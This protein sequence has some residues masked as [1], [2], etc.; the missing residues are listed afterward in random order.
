MIDDDDVPEQFSRSQDYG[1]SSVWDAPQD[2]ALTDLWSTGFPQLDRYWQLYPGQF[3][4]VTGKAG[5]GKSTFLFNV[6]M[7]MAV[8]DGHCAAI[9]VPEN[10]GH[11]RE[12]FTDLW[13]L[14]KPG[15]QYFLQNQLWLQSSRSRFFADEPMDIVT[16][17]QRIGDNVKRRNIDVVLLDPFNEMESC[18]PREQLEAEYIGDL[19]RLVKNFA[20]TF[21]VAI[22][23]VAHPTKLPADENRMPT[24]YDISGSA[25]WANKADHLLVLGRHPDRPVAKVIVRKVRE[26]KAGRLGTVEFTVDETTGL[27]T[28]IC[29]GVDYVD[30]GA[31]KGTHRGH[32]E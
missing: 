15:L 1:F 12:A 6:L 5:S 16:L 29:E 14:D 30:F 32:R 27:F 10:E 4:V 13:Q 19:L 31:A 18:K 11:I 25:N 26:R 23:M 24:E 9:W 20:R 17:L 22:I 7:Q 2:L 8:N 3:T 21:R 28:P